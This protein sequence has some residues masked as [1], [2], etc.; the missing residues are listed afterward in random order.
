MAFLDKSKAN[1]A[2]KSLLGKS[3]TSNGRELSNEAIPSGIILSASRIFADAINS[4]PGN[5]ANAGIVSE[6]V[7]LVLEAVA[8]SDTQ[9]TGTPQ[10]YRC[11]LGGSVP[12]SLSGKVNPITGANYAAN[13]YV[14]NIIPQSFGDA[15]RPI[16]YS[17]AAATVEIPPSSAADWFIDCFAGIVVQE[18]YDDGSA[19]NLGANGRVK[20]Y[21]YTGRFVTEALQSA[22]GGSSTLLE[23]KNSVSGFSGNTGATTNLNFYSGTDLSG[24]P[25]A[26]AASLTNGLR[27]IHIG[28]TVSGQNIYNPSTNTF[29][30]G[31]IANNAIV[32]YYT[33]TQNGYIVQTPTAGTFTSFDADST[34]IYRFN[35]TTWIKQEFEKTVPAEITITALETVE[36]L[37]KWQALSNVALTGSPNAVASVDEFEVHI[38][39]VKAG[40]AVSYRTVSRTP[41]GSASAFTN[42]TFQT[43]L[44]YAV[45]DPVEVTVLGSAYLANIA[46]ITGASAPFTITIGNDFGGPINAVQQITSTAASNPTVLSARLFINT[47]SLGYRVSQTVDN[48]EVGLIYYKRG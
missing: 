10:A 31:S 26:T 30:T 25:I 32:E 38:N 5:S 11:K 40:D 3:H 9:T 19:F 39:G 7:T 45:G 14:G 17:D 22:A 21:I 48:D 44:T 42:T 27:W 12:T 34:L 20:A 47:T 8:G 18:G 46:T 1:Y 13:D 43:S 29:S 28:S 37:N 35:G 36:G 2:F 15:F 41:D 16:L 33:G 4:T 6:L 23:W 24:S